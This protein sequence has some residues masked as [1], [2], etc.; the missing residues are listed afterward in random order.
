MPL[1]VPRLYG[2]HARGKRV[3]VSMWSGVADAGDG[4]DVGSEGLIGLERMSGC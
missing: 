2:S 1:A 3:R 4:D